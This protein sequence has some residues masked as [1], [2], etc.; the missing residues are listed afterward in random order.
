MAEE[1]LKA[2]DIIILDG[3]LGTEL[4]FRGYDL[5]QDPLW[6]A[7]LVQRDPGALAAIHRSY[8]EAGADV[9]TAATYQGSIG[10]M[11]EHLFAELVRIAV[12]TRDEFVRDHQAE[13]EF[14][15]APERLSDSIDFSTANTGDVI[16]N[17]GAPRRQRRKWPLVAVG[18]GPYGAYLGKGQEYT[19]D[20]GEVSKS[21]L[22]EFHRRKLEAL[23]AE[24][25]E[26]EL[27]L[28]E[29]IPNSLELA[30]IADLLQQ[31]DQKQKQP[32]QKSKAWLA[33]S[34][35]FD[36]DITSDGRNRV[37]LADGTPLTSSGSSTVSS[38]NNSLEP[39]FRALAPYIS[40]IG[41][42]CCPLDKVILAL[43][44]LGAIFSQSPMSASSSTPPLLIVYPNSGEIYSGETKTWSQPTT[45]NKSKDVLET[46]DTSCTCPNSRNT[47]EANVEEE[48]SWDLAGNSQAWIRQGARI[49]G[50]CCRTRPADIAKLRKT[51]DERLG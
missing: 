19:G 29:T 40:A 13:I 51:I 11:A 10:P 37:F 25:I 2:S 4:E 33:L 48:C 30:A 24:G 35:S 3:G 17:S 50:G 46:G 14:V 1:R 5:S 21:M 42:N 9:I 49:I 8:L 34:V 39:Q 32:A 23:A 44:E 7:G 26:P 31:Q 38:S 47:K 6:S 28:F 27:L 45:Q 22:I 16:A 43:T 18:M 12:R 15:G 41:V 20:Y 36:K